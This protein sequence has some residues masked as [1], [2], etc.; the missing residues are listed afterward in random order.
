MDRMAVYLVPSC[1]LLLLLFGIF[2]KVSVFDA[3]TEG[4]KEGLRSC[5][6]ILPTLIGLMMA[7]SM[8]QASGAFDVLSSFLRPVTDFLGIPADLV[9]LALMKP[10]S[11]FP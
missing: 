9:P 5:V 10:V 3:F 6:S 2:R 1:V 7:I 4:A 8:L 11:G